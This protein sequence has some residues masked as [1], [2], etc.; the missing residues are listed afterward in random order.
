MKY[1]SVILAAALAL[2]P[3]GAAA[4]T[5]ESLDP[6]VGGRV[7]FTLDKKIVKGLHV[8]IEEEVRFDNNFG[9]FDRFHTT[10]G[11]SYKVLPYLKVG[12][13]YSLFNGYSSSNSAFKTPRHRTFVDV[14]G[15][16]RFGD[17]TVSL[18]ER[19]QMTHRTDSF[20]E[21]QN[22]ANAWAL[23]SRVKVTYKG[24]RRWEPYASF[25]LRTALNEPWGTTSGEAQWNKGGT[26]TY[27]N[28][29]PSGYTHVYNNR[30]R[31]EVG[32]SFNF[33][34]RHELK[35]YL[36]IDYNDKYELDTNA[37]GTKLFSAQYANSI[38]LSPGLSYI[39][40]F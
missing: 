8:S 30:Y 32:V 36:L 16:Y 38:M 28:Y 11:A 1:S 40:S 3:V 20:N 5:E 6:E 18:R 13:G 2:L 34:K 33:S 31:G 24:L 17:W 29:T 9:A 25:E 4:Q 37:E 15:S 14:T 10:L 39:F 27:Y 23:K 7:V 22:P 21:Y 12:L 26:K 35:P 19:V